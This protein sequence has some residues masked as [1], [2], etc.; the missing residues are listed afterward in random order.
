MYRRFF[1]LAAAFLPA[2]VRAQPG[3]ATPEREAARRLAVRRTVETQILPGLAG[4]ADAAQGLANATQALRDAP[5]D[6][7]L[8]AAREAW[9]AASL[10]FQ[11]IRH[12]RFGPMDSFDHGFRI[13]IFPDTRNATGRELLELLRGADPDSITEDAFRR[14]RVA[15]QGLPAAERLLFDGDAARLLTPE[16]H[17]RRLLLAAIG[18]NLAGIAAEMQRAWQAGDPPFARQLEG[19]EG[20]IYRDAG[21]GLLA[22]FKSLHGGIDFLADR[23]LAR[24]LGTSAR[25]ARPRSAEA[26]RSGQSMALALA[27]L[28][29]LADLQ[30]GAVAPLLRQ[31][32]ARLAA[33]ARDVMA[34]ALRQAREVGPSLEAAVAT[35]QGRAAVESLVRTLGLLRRLLTERAAPAIGLPAGFNAMDG[36]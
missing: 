16:E 1:I 11:R 19:A 32:D 36:D 14:G 31:A 15:A 8:A 25:D 27:S 29:A 18:R 24:T 35:P 9:V 28:K 3:A 13:S 30:D 21:E 17:F 5:G 23:Q 26:W 2:T 12:L 10:A 34:T 20:A 4:F 22:L 7:T 6:A 33:E